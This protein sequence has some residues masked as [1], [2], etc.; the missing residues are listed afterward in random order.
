MKKNLLVTLATKEYLLL[1]K[2]LFSSVYFNAGWKGDY[3]LLSCLIPESKLTWF[4]Q[5]GILIKECQP[6]YNKEEMK[7]LTEFNM[8][9]LSLKLLIFNPEFKKWKNIIFLDTD[10]IVRASLNKLTKINGFA[11]VR[12]SAGAL[13]NQ[14]VCEN[15][16]NSI[17]FRHLRQHYDLQQLSFNSGVMAFNTDIIKNNTFSKLKDLLH[18]Y[19]EIHMTADQTVLNLFFYK[20]WQRLPLAYNPLFFVF[21]DICGQRLGEEVLQ[22][23]IVLHFAGF[24]TYQFN[25]T[26]RKTF[27]FKEWRRN[28]HKAKLI[29]LNKI[30]ATKGVWTN[31]K[32]NVFEKKYREIY[33]AYL[34]LYKKDNPVL[35]A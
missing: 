2:Q 1:A 11:A 4:R 20:K 17:F 27:L 3:M 14:F 7:P 23:S 15:K 32:I 26:K 10:I 33:G 12:D 24:L 19:K 35:S 34:K 29:D 6:F 25:S 31:K 28:L 16:E 21:K 9:I 8:P 30:P 5:K 13:I 18:Q 22:K